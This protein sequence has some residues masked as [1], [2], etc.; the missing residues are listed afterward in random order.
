M[1]SRR[2]KRQATLREWSIAVYPDILATPDNPENAFAR[3]ADNEKIG[4][5][6]KTLVLYGMAFNDSRFDAGTG[7]FA[8]GHRLV[9]SPIVKVEGNQYHT[10][11][12]IYI[13]DEEQMREDYKKWCKEN[14]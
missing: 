4:R 3:Y 14:P 5:L 13:L 10:V 12:S 2:N 6:G 11:N 9:T 8:D 1:L 7:E